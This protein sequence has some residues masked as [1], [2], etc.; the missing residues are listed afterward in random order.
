M[1]Q[2]TTHNNILYYV[3]SYGIIIFFITI[4]ISIVNK[5]TDF[6]LASAFQQL[7]AAQ[8]RY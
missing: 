6:P 5:D 8:M 4:C 1:S 3:I 2:I 7:P